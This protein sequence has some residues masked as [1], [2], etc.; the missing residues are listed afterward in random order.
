MPTDVI[1]PKVDM[2]MDAG[3][4]VRWYRQAGETV[5]R[6]EPLLEIETDKS[7]IDVES[8]ASGTLYAI[9]AKV[10]ES[11]PVATR[12]ALIAAPGEEMQSRGDTGTRGHGGSTAMPGSESF[13]VPVS[14]SAAS[15][16]VPLA[17]P[18]SGT[19][20]RATPVAR[21]LARQHGLDLTVVV[22]SGPQ[23][24]IAKRDVLAAVEQKA[25]PAAPVAAPAPPVEIAPP[26]VETA[27]PME[28]R[29]GSA[30]PHGAGELLPL[31]GTRKVIAERLNA[32]ALIPTFVLSVDVEMTQ[33]QAL[34]ERMPGRPSVTAIIA[35][36]VAPLL[37]R[38][39]LLNSSFRADGIWQHH[40]AHLG[41]AM[42]IDGRL[43]VPVVRD[44][45]KLNLREMHSAIGDLRERASKRQIGPAELQGS[46]FSISNLGMLGIDQ[47]TAL[48]N[49][50][51]AAILAVGRTVERYVKG[52]N[53]PLLR[54]FMTLTLS[55][56]HR[57][58]DGAAAARFLNELRSLLE[59]PY[60]MV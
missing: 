12:I 44:A 18:H 53:G 47:F 59:D 14:A 30:Q 31:A 7:T 4:I 35:R 42:D 37:L 17:L 25:V 39:P 28:T 20:P 8:P 5:T 58:A 55:V 60:L 11:I 19:K 1:M 41:I 33:T 36:A 57:V 45:Q 27:P 26:P 23:G 40:T 54:S 24:R 13:L 38:H 2:V 46:T 9:S 16:L 34:R 48:I 3:T 15:G 50:P 6:G 56:D 29:N 51:E 52:D 10:G 43:L 21:A 32:S 22:G 49:P